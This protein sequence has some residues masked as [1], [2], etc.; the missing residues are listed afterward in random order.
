MTP[1]M[2]FALA[3]VPCVVTQGMSI[4]LGGKTGKVLRNISFILG[5]IVICSYIIF[6]RNLIMI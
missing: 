6:I 3:Y 5:G 4:A 1:Q 2:I